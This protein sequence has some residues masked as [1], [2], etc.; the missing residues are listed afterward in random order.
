[1]WVLD[2]AS[3]F[4]TYYILLLWI[5]YFLM[6]NDLTEYTLLATGVIVGVLPLGGLLF[7]FINGKKIVQ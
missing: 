3:I 7:D 2:G 6:E 5:P 1:M 4:A